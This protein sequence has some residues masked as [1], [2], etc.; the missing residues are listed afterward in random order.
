MSPDEAHRLL[1]D[2][3]SELQDR[4]PGETHYDE[5]GVIWDDASTV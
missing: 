3:R 2:L 4:E 1:A 5:H